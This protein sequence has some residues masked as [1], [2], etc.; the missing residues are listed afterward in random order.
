MAST[1]GAP[2]DAL[3]EAVEL[4]GLETPWT[5]AER[6][7]LA[8]LKL[9]VAMDPSLDC[10]RPDLA[11]GWTPVMYASAR[12]WPAV[13]GWLHARGANVHREKS[14]GLTC[15]F[16]AATGGCVGALEVLIRHGC[17]LDV[18][19]QDMSPLEALCNCGQSAALL[20][21]A[22][23]ECATLLVVGGATVSAG[24]V[25]VDA[26]PVMMT[27]AMHEVA[28]DYAP[29]VIT[30]GAKDGDAEENR[31]A[32]AR[33]DDHLLAHISS[34]LR[35]PRSEMRRVKR[36][37]WVWQSEHRDQATRMCAVSLGYRRADR[38]FAV[39]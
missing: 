13:A 31:C 22:R 1:G 30:L 17:D 38:C 7:D 6:G 23:L 27:W 35:R 4:L 20:H 15:V 26:R 9:S 21:S 10:D 16:L 19:H 32:L 3:L 24:Y 14:D 8:A 18:D 2:Q 39:F 5:M 28:S 29:V 37:L 34:F 25:G 36:A 11:Q 33:L 12:N